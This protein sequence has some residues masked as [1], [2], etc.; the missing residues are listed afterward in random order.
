M[1]THE[2]L[3]WVIKA[4]RKGRTNTIFGVLISNHIMNQHNIWEI[5][6]FK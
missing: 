1:A 6:K 3:T 2:T 5:K 4:Y